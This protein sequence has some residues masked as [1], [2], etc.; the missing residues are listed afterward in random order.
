[1]GLV[2]DTSAVVAAERAGAEWER[3][4][5]RVEDEIAVVPAIVYGELLVG[6]RL[7][8]SSSRGA[9]RR[10]RIAALVGRVP[11][12]EFGQEIAEHW[13]HL[14]AQ[15]SRR[16]QLFPANDLTVAA[17]AVHLGFG[18][19]VGDRDETHFRRIAGLRIE[20]VSI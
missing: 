17:T 8:R 15:L 5:T 7:A 20:L 4:L 12:V 2:I 3:L 14:F 19:L 11:V 10:G 18:V 16:G 13:A 9:T 1:V 6:A